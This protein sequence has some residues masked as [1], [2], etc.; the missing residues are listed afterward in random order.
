[1]GSAGRR[2]DT[3]LIERLFDESDR[4]E[5]FQAVRLLEW[6]RPDRGAQFAVGYDFEPSE[7]PVR[8]RAHAS[9]A[10]PAAAI[11]ALRE[12]LHGDEAAK[13]PR[14][15]EMTVSFMGL[16]GPQGVLPEHYTRLVI[17][18]MHDNDHAMREFFDLFNHRVISLFHRAWAKYRLFIEYER[19]LRVTGQSK[20]DPITQAFYCL[21]GLGTPHLRGRLEVEDETLLYFAGHKAMTRPIALSLQLVLCEHFQTAIELQQFHGQWLAIN[22]YEQSR[23]PDLDAAPSM[24]EIG[25]TA[26]LGRRIWDV[27]SK[28]RVRIGPLDYH[29][30]RR[31]L[32]TGRSYL[33][34]CQLVRLHVGPEYDFDVQLI[35]LA[36]DVPRCHLGR[37]GRD[38]SHLGWNTWLFSRAM[39]ENA[40]HAVLRSDGMPVNRI[41]KTASDFGD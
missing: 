25:V 18:R 24:N 17:D 40:D 20:L 32:P 28:F 26:M 11:T 31:F 37:N 13:P 27:Q 41:V 34:L 35:L 2:K 12:G 23:L 29:R 38:G 6:S 9:Q 10:F 4:F 3:A 19:T 7:E 8:F 21:I 39:S 14:P 36:H 30:F 22:Q 33:E 5:F 15:P 1:M 16:T